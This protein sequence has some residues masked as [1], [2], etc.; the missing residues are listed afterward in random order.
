MSGNR[1]T[2]SQRGSAIIQAGL[3]LA[4]L[5]GAGALLMRS[6][7]ESNKAMKTNFLTEDMADMSSQ[8]TRLLSSSAA[9]TQ[10]FNG[11][12]ARAS[13]AVTEVKDHTGAVVLNTDTKF[14]TGN[15]GFEEIRLDDPNV[16]SDDVNVVTGGTGST[17]AV[18]KFKKIVGSAFSERNKVVKIRLKVVTDASTAVTSCFAQ[19]A[20]DTLW[21]LELPTD[22]I[23]YA[24]GNVGI[25]VQT[26]S[27]KLDVSG[28]A[29]IPAQPLSAAATTTDGKKFAIGGTATEYRFNV[30]DDRPIRFRQTTGTTLGKV[31][32]NK[33]S[34]DETIF[35][36]PVSSPAGSP[37]SVP[38]TSD[39]EGS[40]R[41][42]EIFIRNT[43]HSQ[44]GLTI[45]RTQV[46]SDFGGQWKWRTLKVQR[47][48]RASGSTCTPG[49]SQKDCT[50][51]N[52]SASHQ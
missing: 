51:H 32:V 9:C 35:L 52:S 10:T 46:C 15:V 37:T 30:N 11:R 42:R 24:V 34:A 20:S 18:V 47:Y 5:G 40:M 48:T 12:N 45:A 43:A 41:V 17:Y 25:G 38:C 36:T 50:D 19:N 22:N 2:F 28:A 7:D 21:A 6:N 3:A 13:V 31:V 29:L 26:P 1:K 33:A 23:N 8:I 14:G 4:V 44:P 39:L 27:E 16:A 49:T